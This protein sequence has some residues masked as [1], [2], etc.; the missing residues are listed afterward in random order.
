MDGLTSGVVRLAPIYRHIAGSDDCDDTLWNLR[1]E[2]GRLFSRLCQNAASAVTAE[3]GFYLWGWYERNKSWKNI[4]V[5]KSGRTPGYSLQKRIREEL[6]DERRFL[7]RVHFNKAELLSWYEQDGRPNPRELEKAGC[8]H[9]MWVAI[10]TLDAGQLLGI[11][12]DL[13]EAMNPAA[14]R[15]RPKAPLDSPISEVIIKEFRALI[16]GCR[17]ERPFVSG[18]ALLKV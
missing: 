12:A 3:S 13:I 2:S 6:N 5:G 1:G 16:K 14:N 9:I 4:Y 15:S 8:T 18:P 7:E 10:S 11:E 17:F